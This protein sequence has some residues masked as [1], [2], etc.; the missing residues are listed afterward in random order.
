MAK[1]E[2]SVCHKHKGGV[3]AE[4]VEFGDYKNVTY[5]SDCFKTMVKENTKD[6]I[7]T[8]THSIDDCKIDVYFGVL[9][10]EVVIGTGLLS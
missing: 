10:V 2:C 1:T 4:P 3:F 9:S 7:V 5:C 6:I 8:S